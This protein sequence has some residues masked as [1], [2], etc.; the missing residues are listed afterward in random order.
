MSFCN[1]VKSHFAGGSRGKCAIVLD[2]N[3][4]IAEVLIGE[5]MFKNFGEED[6]DNLEDFIEGEEAH[7]ITIINKRRNAAVTAEERAMSV[8]K[9]QSAEFNDEVDIYMVKIPNIKDTVFKIVHC[10]ISCS[11]T[12]QMKANLVVSTYD[13]IAHPFLRA[14]DDHIVVSYVAVQFA[15]KFQQFSDLLRCSWT[16]S[17]ALGGTIHQGNLY[18]DLWSCIYYGFVAQ[19]YHI[20]ALQMFE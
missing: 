4:D 20:Y 2:W 9:I 3:K 5:M 6:H 14:C 10:Y 12:F 19:K 17:I 8:F 1:T 11:V 18:L 7:C 13:V 15:E 16:F